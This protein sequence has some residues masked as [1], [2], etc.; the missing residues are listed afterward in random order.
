MR[1]DSNTYTLGYPFKPWEERK[2]IASG[3]LILKYVRDTVQHKVNKLASPFFV[4]R[5][6]SNPTACA[7]PVLALPN[8]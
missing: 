5:V 3:P 2:A 4:S 1:S 6:K 7:L 8:R